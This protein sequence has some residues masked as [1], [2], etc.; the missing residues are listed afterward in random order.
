MKNCPCAARKGGTTMSK[1][2]F[3]TNINC[4]GCVST[5]TPVLDNAQYISAWRV[6]T[7]SPDK[8]LTV[9]G[10]NIA[11]EEV[12]NLVKQAGYSIEPLKEGLFKRLF[13]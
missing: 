11:E 7:A 1:L 12:I 3:K 9:E 6:D 4:G 13:S 5:V 10:D 8:V 2:K